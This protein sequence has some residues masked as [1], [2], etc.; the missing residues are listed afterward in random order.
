MGLGYGI[1]G[2]GM[3]RRGEL[4]R[5][6]WTR[7]I[8]C[9]SYPLPSHSI[10]NM[11]R[12]VTSEDW[13]VTWQPYEIYRRYSLGVVIQDHCK[14]MCP[15]KRSGDG[16][17]PKSFPRCCCAQSV[18][19]IHKA[20]SR[21]FPRKDGEGSFTGARWSTAT[22]PVDGNVEKGE[23][24]KCWKENL[25]DCLFFFS[26]CLEPPFIPESIIRGNFLMNIPFLLEV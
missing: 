26:L 9:T 12:I 2:Q 6:S 5:W 24:L 14:G 11:A 17:C 23:H 7:H 13:E 19:P 22:F 1:T 3:L 20:V 8:L 10:F 4:E 21:N 18:L 16:T 15:S 25:R